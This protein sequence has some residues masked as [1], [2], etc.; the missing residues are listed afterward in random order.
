MEFILTISCVYVGVPLV[1]SPVHWM[2]TLQIIT[3]IYLS[4]I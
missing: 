3:G 1:T 2:G 4:S